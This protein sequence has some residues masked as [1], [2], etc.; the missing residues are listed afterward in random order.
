MNRIITLAFRQV[1]DGN[2]EF[3]MSDDLKTRERD[4]YPFKFQKLID[5]NIF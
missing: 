4:N 2:G 3:K 1:F 5:L